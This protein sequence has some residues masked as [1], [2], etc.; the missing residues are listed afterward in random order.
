MHA[1]IEA[2]VRHDLDVTRLDV[3][4]AATLAWIDLWLA[5]AEAVLTAETA[6][7]AER[8]AGVTD[9]RFASGAAPRLDVLRA[10]A[11]ALRLRAEADSATL[12]QL[13][14]SARLA[15]WIGH[16]AASL[17]R[18]IGAPGEM[19]ALPALP[20]LLARIDQHALMLAALTR[21][22]AARASVALERRRRWP[23]IGFEVGANFFDPSLATGPAQPTPGFAD[24]HVSLNFEV[25]LFN[26]HGPLIARAQAGV[27]QS[28]WEA[29]SVR[30]RLASDITAAYAEVRAADARARVQR[31]AVFP[32][33]Q[34]AADLALEAYRAG[35]VDINGVLAAQQALADAR[36][37]ANRAEA[38][39]SRA[40][41]TLT[42]A[43]GGPW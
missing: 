29:E 9:E 30:R 40:V 6:E 19:R 14:A 24:A 27:S 38:D 11:E 34:E 43:V 23:I 41:A 7:R 22:S 10:R 18:T 16:D 8:L 37:A 28:S 31:S 2:A 20:I 13:S 26:L 17:L 35:R 36:R 1:A 42:H 4:Y 25:P 32:A 3:R 5:E 39:L 12:A 15:V 33:A 21:T